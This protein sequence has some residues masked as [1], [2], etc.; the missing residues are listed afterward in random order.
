MR[1]HCWNTEV[2][3]IQLTIKLY[4]IYTI[5][6]RTGTTREP[7]SLRFPAFVPGE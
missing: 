2:Y 1:A 3:F 7:D 5:L 6:T 4:V